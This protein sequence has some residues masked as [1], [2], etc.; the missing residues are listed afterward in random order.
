MVRLF[1]RWVRLNGVDRCLKEW[2]ISSHLFECAIIDILQ[3]V[4]SRV[5]DFAIRL[6]IEERVEAERNKRMK[7]R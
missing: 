5:S 7:S 2:R 3:S 1:K 6:W 4:L